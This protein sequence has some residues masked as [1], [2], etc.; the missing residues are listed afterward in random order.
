MS[1]DVDVEQA[2]RDVVLLEH[3]SRREGDRRLGF[4]RTLGGEG[5][6]IIVAMTDQVIIPTGRA[7]GRAIDAEPNSLLVRRAK[8][9]TRLPFAMSN[10][11]KNRMSD[12]YNL[13]RVWCNIAT[14]TEAS[15][16]YA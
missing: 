16:A 2:I 11:R 1:A 9:R 7:S 10:H 6:W 13:K 5:S 15:D 12:R 8:P 3:C 4:R 14:E